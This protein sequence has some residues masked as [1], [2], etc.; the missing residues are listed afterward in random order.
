MLIRRR[1]N[2]T[3]E[4]DPAWKY[5]FFGVFIFSSCFSI[6][7]NWISILYSLY[8]A[9]TDSISPNVKEKS[10]YSGDHIPMFCLRP[11]DDA[12]VVDAS[13]GCLACAR[14]RIRC[15]LDDLKQWL[16]KGI[17]TNILVLSLSVEFTFIIL[18]CVALLTHSWVFWSFG[19]I[20][21]FPRS[22]D[23]KK[24]KK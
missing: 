11:C 18:F 21:H 9:E 16:A 12:Y 23:T 2:P 10:T 24:Q 19:I 17:E 5:I 22:K 8:T 3:T 20:I 13:V 7:L 14:Q 6:F 15:E 4:F 1:V